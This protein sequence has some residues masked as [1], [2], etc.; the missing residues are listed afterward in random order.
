MGDGAR[1]SR[2]EF[3]AAVG[4]TAA[5]LALGPAAR[6]AEAPLTSSALRGAGWGTMKRQFLLPRDITYFNCGT[7][8]PSPRQVLEAATAAWRRLAANPAEVGFGPMLDEAEGVRAKAAA[9]LGCAVDEI[10]LTHST[11]DGM[12]L[13]AQGLD[14]RAGQRVLTTD[15]EHPGGS[16]CWDYLARTRGIVIDR[17][18]LP[19]PAADPGEVLDR[20]ARKLTP[21]TRVISVSHVTF[22]TGLQ[23]P[24]AA[25]ARLAGEERLLLVDGAQAPAGLVLDLPAL[26]CH[27]WA[28]SAHKWLLAPPGTGL[29]YLRRDAQARITPPALQAGYRAYTG[30][31]GTRNFPALLGLGAAV[32]FLTAIGREAVSARLLALRHR[33]AAGLAGLPRV[34]V[35]S[36]PPGPLASQ[37]LTVSLDGVGNEAFARALRAKHGLVVKVVP[38]NLVDGIR[39]S[40][41]VYT[42]DDDLERLQGAIRAEARA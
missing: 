34:R 5:L 21:E 28:T 35:A 17:V 25:L 22:S 19:A 16:L 4:G 14:L 32:D 18:A 37:I 13:L 20:F 41:H 12:N 36:P 11:T 2:R 7:L 38:S 6:A 3:L 33:L 42:T 15:H 29:L 24:L 23:L 8:G 39:I 26:G 40:P 1:I 9:F 31:T 30:A 10:V 27:A